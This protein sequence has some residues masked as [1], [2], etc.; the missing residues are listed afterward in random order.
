MQRW[1]ATVAALVL[2]GGLGACTSTSS[3]HADY[4]HRRLESPQACFKR[5]STDYASCR[6]T[7]RD[8]ASCTRD[9]TRGHHNR[10]ND[11]Q[12]PAQRGSCMAQALE[13]SAGD[14]GDRC[15][16]QHDRC[17]ASCGN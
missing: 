5:C 4:E 6:S 16:E 11:I 14:F 1:T 12:H 13:C 9:V 17:N 10:C 2:I 15:G 3:S 7:S 8:I